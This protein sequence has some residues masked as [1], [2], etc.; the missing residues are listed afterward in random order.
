MLVGGQ[1]TLGRATLVLN[2]KTGFTLV[3][4][5]NFYLLDEQRMGT[6]AVAGMFG[7]APL[8][9]YTDA[10]GDTFAVNYLNNDPADGSLLANNVSVTVLMVSVGIGTLGP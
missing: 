9:I 6:L 10:A 1:L 4:G 3:V 8:G 7:N 2:K 5:W